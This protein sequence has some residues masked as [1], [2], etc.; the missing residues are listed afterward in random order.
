MIFNI[1]TFSFWQ[2][3]GIQAVKEELK[4]EEGPEIGGI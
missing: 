2:I 1:I 4:Q 3:C